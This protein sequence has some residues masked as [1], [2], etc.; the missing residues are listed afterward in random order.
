MTTFNG[1]DLEDSDDLTR[2]AALPPEEG[3]RFV[4]EFVDSMIDALRE[5]DSDV[6]AESMEKTLLQRTD[7]TPEQAEVAARFFA[8]GAAIPDAVTLTLALEDEP[9]QG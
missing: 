2:L 4:A 6:V 3:M 9:S 7:A 5:H 1:I 8:D